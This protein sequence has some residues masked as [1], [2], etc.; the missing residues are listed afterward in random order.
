MLRAEK[1]KFAS[2]KSKIEGL[3]KALF[4]N[5]NLQE[6]VE[7]I[8]SFYAKRGPAFMDLLYKNS[9]SLEQEFTTLF[10]G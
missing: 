3:K 5:N 9:L 1:R 10:V 2:Q 6:R 8:S 7:N 4:P